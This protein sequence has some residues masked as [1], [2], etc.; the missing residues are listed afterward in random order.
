MVNTYD[1]HTPEPWEV[2]EQVPSAVYVKGKNEL[3]QKGL[4]A[5]TDNA[6]GATEETM[7]ANAR[8]IADAPKLLRQR[9]ALLAHVKVL[10]RKRMCYMLCNLYIC[11]LPKLIKEI[12]EG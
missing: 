3:G 10:C 7:E 9:D 1:G 5:I 4:I 8:L 11:T 6:T 12:E 2:G